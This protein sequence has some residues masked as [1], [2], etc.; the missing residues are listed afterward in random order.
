M[1]ILNLN[2]SNK[3]N[4]KIKLL[5]SNNSTTSIKLLN[6][7]QTNLDNISINSDKL[8]ILFR[9]VNE[10]ESAIDRDKTNCNSK[11]TKNLPLETTRLK[12]SDFE[13]ILPNSN[14]LNRRNVHHTPADSMDNSQ[15]KYNS[16]SNFH[17]ISTVEEFSNNSSYVQSY[18]LGH[19]VRGKIREFQKK[20]SNNLILMKKSQTKYKGKQAYL[21]NMTKYAFLSNYD[22]N[23]EFTD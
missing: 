5:S 10:I 4:N 13:T 9:K 23:F 16:L 20:H 2:F 3:E 8:K 22:R 12:I 17:R 6:N 15:L 7:Q 1:K 14:D 11:S 21:N 19:D 18:N